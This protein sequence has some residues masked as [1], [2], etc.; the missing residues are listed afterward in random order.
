MDGKEIAGAPPPAEAGARG[1]ALRPRLVVAGGLA[2]GADRVVAEETA[3]AL[4]YNGSTQAVMM[5]SPADLVDFAHG[6]TLT[7]G[8]ASLEEIADV[9]P[10]ATPRGIDLRIWLTPGAGARL[11]ARRRTMAGPVG[12]GLCG[13][14]SL[15]EAARDAPPVPPSPLRLTMAEVSAAAEALRA[16]QPLH[17]R[18][19]AAHAAGWW[20]PGPGMVAV[21]EDVGRHNALDKLAGAVLRAGLR[22]AEG[23]VVM[24]SRLS[25]DLVQKVARLGSPLL[26]AAS[27]PTAA[28]VDLAQAAGLTLIGLTRPDRFEVFTHPGRIADLPPPG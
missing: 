11:A 16:H 21:R 1:H 5:A 6:F 20:R 14:D 13:L 23:A 3:V 4:S 28:A 17:D 24:T 9:E 22:P 26:I 18:T 19:R 10:V 15:E 27:A 2:T 25:I 7:E 8:L 12:C